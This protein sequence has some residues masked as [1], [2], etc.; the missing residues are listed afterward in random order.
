MFA[1]NH[2]SIKGHMFSRM[3]A[4]MLLTWINLHYFFCYHFDKCSHRVGRHE[5]TSGP[6]RDELDDVLQVCRQLDA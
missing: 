6:K 4:V 1:V 5:V 3:K 2:V